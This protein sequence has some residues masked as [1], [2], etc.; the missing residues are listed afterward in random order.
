[1]SNALILPLIDDRRSRRVL[2]LV[3]V[4]WLLSMA[5]LVFTIW[6]H[7]FTAFHEVN[8]IA[9]ALLVQEMVVAVV[10]FKLALTALG[11]LIFWWLRHHTQA[12]VAMWALVA[13]YV[14]LTV[15]WSNYTIITATI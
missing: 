3:L 8:P 10:L 15:R 4:L 13:V 1:M 9:R 7:H 12:E 6:A 11:T 5:D 14:I 2:E